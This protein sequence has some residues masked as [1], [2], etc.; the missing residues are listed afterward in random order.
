MTEQGMVDYGEE[1]AEWQEPGPF[2][3]EAQGQKLCFFPSGSDR[4]SAL[5]EI[6]D[7]AE[8]SFKAAY[9][10]FVDDDAGN[11]VRDALVRA[12]ERGVDVTLLTDGFGSDFPE[13]YFDTLKQAGGRHEK[14]MAKWSRRYLIRNH[15]KLAV[16][17]GRIAMI[18][19]FNIERDYFAGPSDNGWHDMGLKVEGSA[20]DQ[21]CAWFDELEDWVSKPN[22]QFR[23]IVAKVKSWD[24]G[25]GPVRLLIGG[26]TRGL[27]SWAR[28]IQKDL[29]RGKQ[30][31][32]V[33]AYFS[34]SDKI[35]RRIANIAETGRA[36]LVMAAKSDNGATIGAARSLYHYLL[37]HD[38]EIWEFAPS[39]LHMKLVVLDDAVY[40]GSANFDMRSL[41]VNLEL[42]LR[43]EDA[44]L[45]DRMRAFIGEHKAASN[46]VTREDHRK[47]S[48]LWNRFRWN[49]SW[50]L[51]AVV[52]Y[53]VAR[54]LNLGL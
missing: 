31:D 47:K 53:N 38:T 28:C 43:I 37:K 45:A 34:P 20:V 26:P 21:L 39:K 44:A 2:E 42:M 25:Q 6:I 22:A 18:G 12:A 32:M 13:D 54:R 48:T 49:L 51:V 1:I 40:V 3:I 7:G 30:L 35:M 41:Y 9:Y 4:R 27:S 19:G 5:V 24:S 15:Q 33:M 10:M 11:E 29:K 50:V 36:R 52:D 16:A 8:E 14:F 46:I 17:D 23:Y